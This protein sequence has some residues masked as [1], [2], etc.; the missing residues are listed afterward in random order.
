MQQLPAFSQQL[1]LGDVSAARPQAEQQPQG[2][3]RLGRMAPQL[4]LQK[5]PQAVATHRTL[6]HLAAHD[7]AAAPGAGGMGAKP[8]WEQGGLGVQLPQ[9]QPFPLETAALAIEPLKD[10][11]APQ[12]VLGRQGHGGG[13]IRRRDGRGRGGDGRG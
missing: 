6:V 13:A 8:G 7:D 11:V 9:D 2:T 3:A 4:L 1:L 10:P 12:P 5:A